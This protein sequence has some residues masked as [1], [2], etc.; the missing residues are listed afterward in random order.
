MPLRMVCSVNCTS[1]GSRRISLEWARNDKP[2]GHWKRATRPHQH[3]RMTLETIATLNDDLIAGLSP[4]VARS[5]SARTANYQ[6][7]ASEPR[8]A[9]GDASCPDRAVARFPSLQCSQDHLTL[10]ATFGLQ[11]GRKSA[12]LADLECLISSIQQAGKNAT[13]KTGL[14]KIDAEKRSVG[15]YLSRGS[16]GI[17]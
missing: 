13:R 4:M 14:S 6:R 9:T 10:A 16:D 12:R 11:A 5:N 2:F 15:L 1:G 7:P 8:P 17:V 3:P